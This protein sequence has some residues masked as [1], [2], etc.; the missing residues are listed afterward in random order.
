MNGPDR[1]EVRPSPTDP[2]FT[3]DRII[4]CASRPRPTCDGSGAGKCL[5][6]SHL[7]VTVIY[8]LCR[9]GPR[10]LWEAIAEVWE[11]LLGDRRHVGARHVVGQRPELGLGERGVEAGEVLVLG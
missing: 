7:K 6:R 10:A 11:N 4:E 5:R 3:R 9:G 2:G 1:V 8:L